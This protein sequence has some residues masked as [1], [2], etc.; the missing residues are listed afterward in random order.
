MRVVLRSALALVLSFGNIVFLVGCGQSP[1]TAVV[2][3]EAETAAAKSEQTPFP[4]PIV[5][6]TGDGQQ[7]GASHGRALLNPITLLL[8]TYIPPY[9]GSDAQRV[10]ALAAASLFEWHALPE[11]AAEVRSLALAT[12]LSDREAMLGKCFL[13]LAPPM[14][15]STI[16]LP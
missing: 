8:D 11:H 13:A 7:M 3:V 6:L 10:R 9:L 1:A 14:G 4:I 2:T 12:G 15:C 5:E 16:A